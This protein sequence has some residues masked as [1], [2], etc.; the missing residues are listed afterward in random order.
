MAI[1]QG[2][3]VAGTLPYG[4]T[5]TENQTQNQATVQQDAGF[6]QNRYTAAQQAAQGQA[7]NSLS[8]VLAGGSIP[9]SFGLPQ[10]VYDAA[11]ANFNKF[12]APLL[13]AQHGS[14]TPAINSA[15]QELQLQL[16]GMAGQNAASNFQGFANTLGHYAF[17]PVGQDTG[18][19]RAANTNTVTNTS[20]NEV[21]F[22]AGGALAALTQI[23]GGG[24][25][26]NPFS[27]GSNIFP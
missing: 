12:Q 8:S 11:F 24:Q 19:T 6:Q 25:S 18:A 21:G 23:L 14:G 7:L 10:S 4:S 5:T 1:T 13:A 17:T 27:T 15:M 26:T 20:R 9:S 2:D 16:A 22:D 3:Q